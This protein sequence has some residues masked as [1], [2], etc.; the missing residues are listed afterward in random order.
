MLYLQKHYAGRFTTIKSF[1]NISTDEKV[2]LMA[3]KLKAQSQ[4]AKFNITMS[5]VI[6]I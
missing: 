2:Y 6:N 1:G 4:Q 3:N 5:S